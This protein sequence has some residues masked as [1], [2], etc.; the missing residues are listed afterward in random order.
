[1]KISS[2]MVLTWMV[3][4]NGVSAQD[5]YKKRFFG[6]EPPGLTPEEFAPGIISL[7]GHVT[8]SITFSPDMNELFFARRKQGESHNIYTMKRTNGRWS[9]PELASFSRNKQYLDFHV[10]FSPQGDRIYFGSNRPIGD[11]TDVA[12]MEQWEN[13]RNIDRLHLWS[14]QRIGNGWGQPIPFLEEPLNDRFI[15]CATPSQNGNLYFT[16]KEKNEKLEDEGI[17]YAINKNGDYDKVERLGE[18]INGY[19]KWIAHPFVAPDESYLLYDAERLSGEENG[20]LYVSF[21]KNGEWSESFSLGSEINSELGQGTATVSPDGKYLFFSSVPKEEEMPRLY[22][23]STAVIERLRP[24]EFRQEEVTYEIAYAS[25]ASR[26]GEV[27]ITDKEGKSR[28]QITD[29]M[30]NDGYAAWSPDG[31]RIACYAYHD[32]RKTWSIHAMNKDGSN[33]QRLTHAKNKWDSAPAWS[34]DGKKIAFGRAY[35]DA[36]S[37]WN[38]EIWTMNADGSD[39]LQL[40]SLDGGAPSFTPDGRIVFHSTPNT[41]EI[42]IADQDGSNKKQLTNNESEDWHPEVSPDGKEIVFMSDR[43]GNHEIYVMNIDGSDPKRL[44]YNE[45]RDSTPTW[46]PDGTQILFTSNESDG[47]E[48]NIYLMNRDGTGL[49]KLIEKAGAPAWLK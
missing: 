7:D 12:V 36:G 4:I 37:V 49:R 23:V 47:E 43:D 46:S 22:W 10:R 30:G 33:R 9:K 19:G 3:M 24:A 17:Y 39:Q 15:M 21:H 11:T 31:K 34:P 5:N 18:T 13:R 32:G 14:V 44:T 42:F 2:L 25:K 26:D 40:T 28:I 45:V 35:P 29:R 8:A 16:S 38:H 41:S 1:M 27:F 6:Q 20:D 48:R